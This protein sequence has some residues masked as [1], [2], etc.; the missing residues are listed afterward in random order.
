MPK[1]GETTKALSVDEMEV[2]ASY[3]SET[4]EAN[5]NVAEMLRSISKPEH[6]RNVVNNYI[7]TWR[8]TD[9]PAGPK[10]V[11][12][13]LRITLANED[14]HIQS[15]REMLAQAEIKEEEAIKELNACVLE[16]AYTQ[17]L[18]HMRLTGYPT[19]K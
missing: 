5:M 6:W 1:L 12:G 15:L 16:R 10:I 2:L 8:N 19:E 4:T 11:E 13:S 7:T 18:L 9:V 17:E 3:L 14:T